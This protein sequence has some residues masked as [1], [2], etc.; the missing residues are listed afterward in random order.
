[1]ILVVLVAQLVHPQK[2][3]GRW[4]GWMRVKDFQKIPKLL[5]GFPRPAIGSEHDFIH[6][7]PVLAGAPQQLRHSAW[8]A[9]PFHWKS[10][11]AMTITAAGERT[12]CELQLKILGLSMLRL[13]SLWAIGQ[14]PTVSS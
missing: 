11:T 8:L 9:P 1:M 2:V 13:S 3:E 10:V 5:I 4:D 12:K 7:L 6:I 14:H